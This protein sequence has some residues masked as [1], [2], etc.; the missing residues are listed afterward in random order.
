MDL[1][2][3]NQIVAFLQTNIPEIKNIYELDSCPVGILQ[4][5]GNVGIVLVKEVNE[6]IKASHLS[7]D[8]KYDIETVLN[9]D[10]RCK[11][12][13]KGLL[14]LNYVLKVLE[15]NKRDINEYL[16]IILIEK[17]EDLSFLQSN[18]F[19][20]IITIKI[21]SYNRKLYK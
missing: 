9:I 20:K 3:K 15:L 6:N 7:N 18:M 11:S 17:I 5:S 12:K 1:D 4:N 14:I 13:N 21:N 8:T 2:I 16:N 19:R 10:I